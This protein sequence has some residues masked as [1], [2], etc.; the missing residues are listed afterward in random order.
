MYYSGSFRLKI[1]FK[2]ILLIGLF[3]LPIYAYALSQPASPP[4]QNS[5]KIDIIP[6]PTKQTL[7]PAEFSTSTTDTCRENSDKIV[8]DSRGIVDMSNHCKP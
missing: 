5:E 6:Q 8:I 7:N 4:S 2:I 1:F 3:Q